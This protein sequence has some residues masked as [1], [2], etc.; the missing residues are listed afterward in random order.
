MDYH[1]WKEDVVVGSVIGLLIAWMC[2]RQYFPPIACKKSNL[3]YEM[4]QNIK[5]SSEDLIEKEIKWI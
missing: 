3:C 1:H 4:A 5:E 2:Y